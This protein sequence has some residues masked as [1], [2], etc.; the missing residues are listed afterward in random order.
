MIIFFL[1]LK[2]G[3]YWISV[4]CFLYFIYIYF[5]YRLKRRSKHFLHLMSYW[6]SQ[7]SLY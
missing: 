4:T 1:F 2:L 5:L 6:R 7:R 3:D